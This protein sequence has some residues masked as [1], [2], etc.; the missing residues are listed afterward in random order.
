MGGGGEKK[1]TR[2]DLEIIIS[3]ITAKGKKK[4]T[5]P[6]SRDNNILNY[7]PGEKEKKIS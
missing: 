5:P 6:G 2:Q 3:R 7:R 4:K 1:K